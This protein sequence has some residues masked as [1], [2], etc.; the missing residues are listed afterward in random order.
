MSRP[1]GPIVD[2]RPRKATLTLLDQV[3]D[4]LVE[5]RDHLPLT[6]RQVFYRLVGAH[7]Y[8]KTENAY[9][10]LLTHIGNARRA[11][12]IAWTSIRDDGVTEDRPLGFHDAAGF[13][14][15]VQTLA[16]NYRLDRLDGQPV[17]VE[18]WCEAAG[19]L[20]QLTRV[21][22]PYGVAVFSS[23]GFDSITFKHASARRAATAGRPLVVLHVGDHDPSGEHLFSSAAEDVTAWA[24]HYGAQV[25]FVRVAVTAEQVARYDLPTTPP[26]PTDRRSYIDS[27]TAQAE[28]LDPATL[29]AELTHAIEG[30]TDRTVLDELLVR[31]AA[32]R[33]TLI[34]EIGG[35]R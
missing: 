32:E 13:R 16:G 1:R 5:Y 8:P 7:G 18:V 6:G 10:N 26:K 11:G 15:F 25:K 19:M 28:A 14:S 23:S 20:P 12:L 35:R 30:F 24:D 34:T 27:V 2:Y 17:L 9:E 29:A 22:D 21:A 33:D 4:V 31:E 3:H